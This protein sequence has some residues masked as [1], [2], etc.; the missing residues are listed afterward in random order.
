MA[1]KELGPQPEPETEPRGPN[2]GGVDAIDAADGVDGERARPH[3]DARDL[4]PEDN[5]AT[6]DALPDEMTQTEDTS[7][8]ATKGDDGEPDTEA[9]KESPA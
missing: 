2:P 3:P 6:E 9:E 5:P 4:D 1:G 8:E 7:T